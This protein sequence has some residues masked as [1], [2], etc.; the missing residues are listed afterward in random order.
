MPNV[1]LC[2]TCLVVILLSC[3]KWLVSYV[4]CTLRVS[5][6][7]VPRVL[8]VLV[9]YLSHILRAIVPHALRAVCTLIHYVPSRAFVSYVPRV[10]HA[11]V[12]HVL[13]TVRPLGPQVFYVLLHL[14]CLMPWVF[15]CCFCLVPRVL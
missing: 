11:L 3:V 7:D 2:L 5:V 13:C 10:L 12:I 14:T 15:S 6:L 8:G 1:L 4:F 9:I